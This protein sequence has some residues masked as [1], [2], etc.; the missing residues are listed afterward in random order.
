MIAV[1]CSDDYIAQDC[2]TL[3]NCSINC[4]HKNIKRAKITHCA[5]IT[6]MSAMIGWEITETNVLHVLILRILGC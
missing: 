6:C 1:L 3:S 4:L 5:E 2:F